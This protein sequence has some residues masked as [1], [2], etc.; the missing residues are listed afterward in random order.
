MLTRHP[1][2]DKKNSRRHFKICTGKGPI[3]GLWLTLY[4]VELKQEFTGFSQCSDNQVKWHVWWLAISASLLNIFWWW[5]RKFFTQF[6]DV[7]VNS[8]HR[9]LYGYPKLYT[10]YSKPSKL[11]VPQLNLKLDLREHLRSCRPLAKGHWSR[12]PIHWN[13]YFYTYTCEKTCLTVYFSSG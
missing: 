6:S 4:K 13:S 3:T 5:R 11:E 10:K 9:Y 12:T 8:Y 1:S 7:C 2:V